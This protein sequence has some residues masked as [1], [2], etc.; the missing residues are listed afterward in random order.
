MLKRHKKAFFAIIIGI[1]PI[2]G[3]G[4]NNSISPFSMYGVGDLSSEGFGRN[5]GMGGVSSPLFSPFHLNPS[6]PASYLGI[7]PN[8]FIFEFGL[9]G[10]YYTLETPQDKV[11]S[12]NG[13]INYVAAGFP[14]TNWWKAGIGLRPVSSIGYDIIVADEL[15]LSNS[16]V[17]QSYHGEGG[18]NS[19]YFDNSFRIVKPLS[20]GVKI[21][22]TFGTLDRTRTVDT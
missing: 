15:E 11:T 17:V 6:N 10:R 18:L 9:S 3:Q 21:A 1:M 14:I 22:Y 12:F 5:R 19:F 20:L 4:Q 16:L 2:I 7:R 8:S 13:T